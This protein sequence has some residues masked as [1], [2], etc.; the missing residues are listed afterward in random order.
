MLSKIIQKLN[1]DEENH[2][3][4]F[5]SLTARRVKLAIIRHHPLSYL[6]ACGCETID[7]K[8]ELLLLSN[9]T[10]TENILKDKSILSR[11]TVKN[12]TINMILW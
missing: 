12:I 7:S 5:K 2:E 9:K 11:A 1:V 4:L 3:N 6:M 10:T 8:L